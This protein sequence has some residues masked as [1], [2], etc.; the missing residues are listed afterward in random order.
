M[1]ECRLRYSSDQVVM[2][3]FGKVAPRP[4]SETSPEGGAKPAGG[5]SPAGACEETG[6]ERLP[7]AMCVVPMSMEGIELAGG[8][9][10][11]VSPAQ[12]ARSIAAQAARSA[13]VW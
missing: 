3:S 6:A 4:S 9:L 7:L 5:W 11:V 8:E 1:L 10:F 13:V 2:R 12:P